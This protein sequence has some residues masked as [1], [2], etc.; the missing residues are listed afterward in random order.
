MIVNYCT[1]KYGTGLLLF[2]CVELSEGKQRDIISKFWREEYERRVTQ[3]AIQVEVEQ[4]ARSKAM[5]CQGETRFYYL[6]SLIKGRVCVCQ[7]LFRSIRDHMADN[8]ARYVLKK[9]GKKITPTNHSQF[10]LKF[11]VS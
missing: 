8:V 10:I 6:P 7:R 11:S 4:P 2:C 9:A 1:D 3:I 5:D